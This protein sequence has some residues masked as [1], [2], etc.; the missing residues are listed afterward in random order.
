LNQRYPVSPDGLAY[1]DCSK[2]LFYQ[3]LKAKGIVLIKAGSTQKALPKRR[4]RQLVAS[5]SG[6]G[7]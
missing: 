1:A 6:I 3:E 7:E 4:L 2:K 5:R